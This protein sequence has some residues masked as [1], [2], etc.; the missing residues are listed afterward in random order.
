MRVLP[1]SELDATI[2]REDAMTAPDTAA[3]DSAADTATNEGV[4]GTPA[5]GEAP[6]TTDGG[7]DALA[8]DG[9]S[10]TPP[11]EGGEREWWDP[12]SVPGTARSAASATMLPLAGLTWRAFWLGVGL[13][14]RAAAAVLRS[15]GEDEFAQRQ[16]EAALNSKS[17]T[18]IAGIAARSAAFEEL[19]KHL[20]SNDGL[21]SL[22]DTVAASP[23]VRGAVARQGYG[24]A[25]EVGVEVRGRAR[26]AD[27][28]LE[29][30]ARSVTRGR[31]KGT[32]AK[33]TP[34]DAK[35]GESP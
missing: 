8:P 23:A 29:R 12:R 19:L 27:D 31:S 4:T 21:W 20:P 11:P 3:P 9:A 14:P 10:D 24:L 33:T 30:V 34:T 6:V 22:I 7:A 2:P 5:S 15:A 35:P 32:R 25:D 28:Y 26:S 17:A 18:T 13:A 16:L 1:C